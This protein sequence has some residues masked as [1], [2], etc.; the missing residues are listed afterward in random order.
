MLSKLQMKLKEDRVA[1]A[2]GGGICS[3]VL[4]VALG[5]RGC[6]RA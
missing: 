3:H 2:E 5:A 6:G 1:K 4:S